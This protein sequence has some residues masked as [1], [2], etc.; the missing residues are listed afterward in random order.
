MAIK[1]KLRSPDGK[2]VKGDVK[3]LEKAL[4]KF[5]SN[6]IKE[7]RKILNQKRKEHRRILYLMIIITK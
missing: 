4:T 7:G 1:L 6:V 5:G 3:H 2:Y